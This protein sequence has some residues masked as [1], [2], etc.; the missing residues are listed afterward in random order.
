VIALLMHL[1]SVALDR[2]AASA[3]QIGNGSIT[4]GGAP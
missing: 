4:Q 3:E 1:L 2:T